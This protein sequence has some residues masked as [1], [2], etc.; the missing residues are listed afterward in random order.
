MYMR[1]NGKTG[2]EKGTDYRKDETETDRTSW[3]KKIGIRGERRSKGKVGWKKFRNDLK[4]QTNSDYC[5]H[6]QLSLI[7]NC[8]LSCWLPT[9]CLRERA[10]SANKSF[11]NQL[12]EIL[13]ISYS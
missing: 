7:Y 11:F 5:S 8:Q 13:L 12:T 10:H 2:R 1:L 6:L 4:N 9:T 3:G